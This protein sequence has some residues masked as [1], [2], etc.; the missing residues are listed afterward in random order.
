MFENILK[1]IRSFSENYEKTK[2]LFK[3][4][5]EIKS[6][7]T[8]VKNSGMND[9][10]VDRILKYQ[11]GDDYEPTTENNNNNEQ[12]YNNQYGEH[13]VQYK[14]EEKKPA[15]EEPDGSWP[16][17]M[18]YNDDTGGCTNESNYETKYLG[19]V[20]GYMA[21]Y[22]SINPHGIRIRD[23]PQE[24]YG[25]EDKINAFGESKND[26]C[27]VINNYNPLDF[28]Q[29]KLATPLYKVLLANRRINGGINTLIVNNLK[30][31]DEQ[32]Y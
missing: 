32:Q 6:G 13:N 27:W 5:Q 30:V 24:L 31:Q 4:M 26:L 9:I 3:L 28:Q 25:N 17:G 1:N 7:E 2:S 14:E 8:E 23:I 20:Q 29:N 21:D 16:Y 10:V 19:Q 12:Q 15:P 11:Y 18:D 22:T